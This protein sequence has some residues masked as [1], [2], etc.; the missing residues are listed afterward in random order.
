MKIRRYTVRTLQETADLLG[1][2][3]ERVRQIEKV[4][5][6]KIR[7]VLAKKYGI[8]SFSQMMWS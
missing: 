5:F 8:K 6:E 4:A 3:R 2:S 1:L 7:K